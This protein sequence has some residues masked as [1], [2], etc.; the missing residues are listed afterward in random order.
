MLLHR[1]HFKA[2]QVPAQ[3]ESRRRRQA[4]IAEERELREKAQLEQE[5]M[6]GERGALKAALAAERGALE[7]EKAKVRRRSRR[8]GDARIPPRRSPAPRRLSARR[9]RWR[10][11]SESEH[12]AKVSRL[13]TE[14]DRLKEGLEQ[15]TNAMGNEMMHWKS[16]G[17]AASGVLAKDG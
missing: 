7:A 8:R 15:R 14:I 9:R 13:A 10:S 2:E 16:G 12:N 3:A 17:A 1:E 4:Q 6:R 11:S 5:H